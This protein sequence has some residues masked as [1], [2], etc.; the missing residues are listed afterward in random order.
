M[1]GKFFEGWTR[2]EK[3]WLII[4]AILMVAVSI[5][6]KDS[7]IG[8]ASGLFGITSV[9][10]AAKGKIS[11]YYLGTIQIALYSVICFQSHFYGTLIMNIIF[12]LPMNVVG[13]RQWK[14]KRDDDGNV[15]AKKLTPKQLVIVVIGMALFVSIIG[16][17]LTLLGGNSTYLDAFNM[18]NTMLAM[19]LMVLRYSENWIFWLLGNIV[20]VA[21]WI[22]VIGTP[23]FNGTMIIIYG[24]YLFN[25]LYGYVNWMRLNVKQKKEA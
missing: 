23:E 9:V 24:T 10:M 18:I 21:M 6:F 17:V 15:E 13:Y 25:A 11:T 2:F 7:V 14:N 8:L 1:K 22:S 3:G 19:T 4:S 16:S 20:S 5:Y 12:Y